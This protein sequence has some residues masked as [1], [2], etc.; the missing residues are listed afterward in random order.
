MAN[1]NTNL[2]F[3][4]IQICKP[5][6]NGTVLQATLTK[7]CVLLFTMAK[8]I[9]VTPDRK[10]KFD[11]DNKMITYFSDTEAAQVIL[12]IE[13]ALHGIYTNIKMPHLTSNDPKNIQ[14]EFSDYNGNAQCK[15]SLISTTG[16]GMYSI[17][18]NEAEMYLI[19]HNLKEQISLYN[20]R[21]IAEAND[22]VEFKSFMTQ[23][24]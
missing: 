16:K 7:K 1:D 4:Q 19:M 14:L 20:K 15:F 9:G 22:D 13:K 2:R 24:R 17:Y 12:G 11:Y 3:P 6:N 23:G 10:A 21:L 5:G 8:Q 18:L